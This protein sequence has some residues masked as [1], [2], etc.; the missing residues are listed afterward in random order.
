[1]QDKTWYSILGL[2]AEPLF[3]QDGMLKNS[4]AVWFFKV[5]FD[6]VIE[7]FACCKKQTASE[8]FKNFNRISGQKL[9]FKLKQMDFVFLK[10]RPFGC[11]SDILAQQQSN[12]STVQ[13]IFCSLLSFQPTPQQSTLPYCAV[14]G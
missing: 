3:L 4:D 13:W 11:S 7:N 8:F 6:W 5:N 12:I 2:D 1:M 9:Q 14:I 10:P